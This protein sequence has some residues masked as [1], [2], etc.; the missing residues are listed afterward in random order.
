MPQEHRRQHMDSQGKL[1]K[2]A[3]RSLGCV[4]VHLSIILDE[5]YI[6]T[7]KSFSLKTIC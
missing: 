5:K 1:V 7:L 6:A 3:F 4:D 2:P